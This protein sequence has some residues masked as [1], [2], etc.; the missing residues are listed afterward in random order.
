M[1]WAT[2]GRRSGGESQHHLDTKVH[3]E[4]YGEMAAVCVAVLLSSCLP[5]RHQDGLRSPCPEH[6]AVS[7][8]PCPR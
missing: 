7:S 6:P 2:S 5:R 8:L 3:A 4:M 1:G